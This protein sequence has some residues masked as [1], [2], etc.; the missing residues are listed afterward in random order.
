MSLSTR[1]NRIYRVVWGLV[2]ACSVWLAGL[3]QAL[4]GFQMHGIPTPVAVTR[5]LVAAVDR[6]GNDVVLTWLQDHRGGY[7]LLMIDAATG[8]SQQFAL[9]FKPDGGEPSAMMLSSRNRFYTM[10]S[11]YFLEFDPVRR[12]FSFWHKTIDGMAM[13]FTED[14]QGRIWAANY[15]DNRIVMFDPGR[16]KLT[17][18]GPL[19]TE[20]WRQYPRSI[21]ADAGGWIYV[22]V[23][24]AASQIYALDTRSGKSR[25]LLPK[26]LRRRGTAEV[27]QSTA[28]TVYAQNGNTRYM[29]SNG[30]VHSLPKGSNITMKKAVMTGAQN[31]VSWHF[32]S[33]RQFISIDMEKRLLVTRVGGNMGKKHTVRFRYDTV[34]ALL[35]QVCATPNGKVCGGTRFPMHVFQ[36]DLKTKAFDSRLF[37]RQPNVIQPGRQQTYVAGYPEGGLFVANGTAPGGFKRLVTTIPEITRPHALVAYSKWPVVLMGGTPDYGKSGGGMLFW[38]TRTGRYSLKTHHALIPWQSVQSMIELKDG[39]ILVGTTTKAGTGGVHGKGSAYLYLLD[40][41]SEKIVWKEQVVPGAQTITDLVQ[42][43]DGLVYGLADSVTLFT[44]DPRRRTVV[45]RDYFSRRRLGVTIFAQGTRAFVPVPNA[46]GGE[47]IYVL[48]YDWIAQI[49]TKTHTLQRVARSPVHVSVGGAYLNGRI[50][51]GSTSR[52]YSWGVP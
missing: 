28:N 2:L 24:H 11:G 36:Y 31:L 42:R 32:P 41:Y 48:M 23:G 20:T 39:R 8:R 52:L 1:K 12:G 14:A 27:V 18:Y 21:A 46:K 6:D 34:G 19:S 22:G 35:T 40:P 30:Q 29:L 45:S 47:R 13:S 51:F 25:P 15:P 50:Y 5:G 33:G 16:R 44:F 26:N 7:A 38:N 9:P 17:N 4:A 10:F 3:S 43:A 49:D 37:D